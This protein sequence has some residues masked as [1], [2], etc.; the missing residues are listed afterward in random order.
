MSIEV[1]KENVWKVLEYRGKQMEEYKRVQDSGT[2]RYYM[3]RAIAIDHVLE[4]LG[5]PT[6]PDELITHG[7]SKSQSNR[8]YDTYR[9][10]DGYA[11]LGKIQ[12]HC[13]EVK[14]RYFIV[15]KNGESRTKMVDTW[16]EA[17]AYLR[18]E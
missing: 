18:V 2:R 13:R 6:T 15:W 10:M 16:D 8:Y 17:I 14:E 1:T 5:L 7:Y 12:D 3:N 11:D 4:L 9:I